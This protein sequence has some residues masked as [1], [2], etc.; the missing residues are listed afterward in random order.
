MDIDKVH[1]LDL[2]SDDFEAGEH[3]KMDK[4]VRQN[5]PSSLSPGSAPLFL[6]YIVQQ[7]GH[8]LLS[9]YRNFNEC[10][11]VLQN[12]PS[13]YDMLLACLSNSSYK[14]VRLLS[15]DLFAICCLHI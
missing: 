13:I 5:L 11:T 14:N 2:V 4:D 12:N 10:T 6:L 3:E 7:S 1:N 8:R 15:K 9:K